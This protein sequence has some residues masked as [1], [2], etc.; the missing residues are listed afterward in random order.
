LI[1]YVAGAVPSEAPQRIRNMGLGLTNLIRLATTGFKRGKH[2]R[3]LTQREH[4]AQ[5][6]GQL[7]G[8]KRI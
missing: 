4:V 6:A 5:K 2:D 8:M 7:L 1:T 3:F